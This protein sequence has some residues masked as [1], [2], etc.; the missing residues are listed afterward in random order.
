MPNVVAAGPMRFSVSHNMAFC[1]WCHLD[2]WLQPRFL[3]EIRV[4][5][6]MVEAIFVVNYLL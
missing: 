4:E 3:R 2:Y 1:S 5:I 6:R